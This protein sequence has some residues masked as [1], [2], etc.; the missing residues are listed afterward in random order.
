MKIESAFLAAALTVTAMP[1]DVYSTNLYYPSPNV[2]SNSNKEG[3]EGDNSEEGDECECEIVY[4]HAQ[5]P[6]RF[7]EEQHYE[8]GWAARRDELSDDLSR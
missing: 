7:V 2:S 8:V 1:M 4:M 3:E 6:D 5:Q